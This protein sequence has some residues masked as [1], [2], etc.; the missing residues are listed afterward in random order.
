MPT[1]QLDNITKRFETITAVNNLN[2]EIPDRDYVCI[3]G[4]T[5]SGKTTLLKLIAGLLM[6]TEGRILLD[7]HDVTATPPET[8]DAVYVP[9]QYALF[10]HMTIL[11]NVAF[12]PKVQG[13]P[14]Q[15]AMRLAKEMLDL[16]RLGHRV[17]SFPDE[18]SGGMQQRVALAR[19]LAAEAKLLLLDEP[20][21]ALDARLRVQLRYALRELAKDTNTTTIHVTHDQEEAMA[22]ADKI[23]VLRQG[24]VEQ[25]AT[26]FHVYS[27]PQTLFSAH[28][29]GESNF[30]PSAIVRRNLRDSTTELQRGLQVRATDTTYS[31]GE[32]IILVIREDRVR[33]TIDMNKRIDESVFNVL[34]GEIR[35][36]QFL[37][38]FVGY[39]IRL[40]NGDVLKA[41]I[42]LSVLPKPL[43]QG[44]QVRAY[45]AFNDVM[46]YSSPLA[47]L[48]R[49]LEVY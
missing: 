10:P 14:K 36:S 46:M 21:G 44:E 31:V 25:Y 29:V 32:E 2:L 13:V 38:G 26:P 42:P 12:G 49:E 20:L 18:L 23:A 35:A 16:M 24:R 19:G 39:Q 30:L 43:I 47:G 37:G 48:S 3:L 41:R 45:F 22:V 7:G 15:R 9:Q 27:K 17:D 40:S 11:E 28:F 4:P 33:V 34:A 6:P 1:V 5:G 8:R